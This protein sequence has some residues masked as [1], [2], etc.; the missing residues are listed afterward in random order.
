MKTSFSFLKYSKQLDIAHLNL[1]IFNKQCAK[2]VV[3]HSPGLVDFAFGLVNYI[4]NFH[5]WQVK[6]FGGILITEE[7]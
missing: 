4:L 3:S 7:L 5:D 2:K 1:P 6:F